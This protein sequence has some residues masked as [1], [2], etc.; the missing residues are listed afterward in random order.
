MR[1]QT[2]RLTITEFT[3]AM[4]RSHH[5]NSLDADN[6]EFLS[7]EVCETE[8]IARE[9]IAWLAGYY[10]KA[11][12]PLVYPILLKDGIH[13]GHVQA[14]PIKE[15]WE[16]GYHIAAAHAGQGYAAEATRAFLP[17]VMQRL[18]INKIMG[19]VRADNPASRRVLEKCGFVLESKT[20]GT[21]RYSY[22]TPSVAAR[23]LPQGGDFGNPTK[24]T[25]TASVAPLGEM[26]KARGG[27]KQQRIR[28]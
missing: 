7:D 2:E 17:V 5:L 9:K 6:R 13:I 19:V 24:V 11:D 23:H 18:G 28:P 20:R 22:F 21:C 12:G 10:E 16:I 1:I 27:E 15:G 8:E 4:A 3:Q 26:A 25:D 14:C